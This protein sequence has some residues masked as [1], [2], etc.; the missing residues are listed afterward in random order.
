MNKM[1]R[2]HWF[3]I[4]VLQSIIAVL[5][6]QCER[7]LRIHPL[8]GID[9]VDALTIWATVITLVFLV[10]SVMGLMN[11]ERKID[12]VEK[13]RLMQEQK[14]KEIEGKSV[15]IVQSID[16]A[17]K[18]IIDKAQEQIKKITND[19][20]ERINFFDRLIAVLRTPMPDRQI[21][22]YTDLLRETKEVKGIDFAYI[23]IN[24]GH[25]YLM[26]RKMK[27]AFTDFE[28]AIKVCQH[29]NKESAYSSMAYYYV[30]AGDYEKSI[31]Y[32]SKALEV[33]PQSARLCMDMGNSLMKMRRFDEADSYFIQAL[34]Y[35][36][37]MA[38]IYYN[39]A[40]RLNEM[41]GMAEKEQK[42]AYLN[43]CIGINPAF[44]KAYI[45][46][47]ALYREDKRDKEAIS[48]L[49]QVICPV[50]NEE[51]LMAVEQRGIAYRL[52]GQFPQALNDFKFVLLF[53]PD[54]VQNLSNLAMTCLKMGQFNEAI[55]YGLLGLEQAKEQKMHI[56][57]ADLETVVNEAKLAF[58]HWKKTVDDIAVRN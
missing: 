3:I 37:E 40:V 53:S 30:V 1:K 44:I 39:K 23:Y 25:A 36:P 4:I 14:F 29:V 43:K 35:N 12:E 57:D 6:L 34:S 11:I 32:Y 21:M 13:S 50:Y 26:L 46:K 52:T 54:N 2:S 51:L 18:D 10:F 8:G 45:N 42:L 56:C 9:M 7:W 24:R 20:T 55:H 38:E 17:K 19:S 22:E 33:N 31:E 58:E 47:A 28:T 5:V 16:K 15:D 27:E 41:E 48:I 49:N